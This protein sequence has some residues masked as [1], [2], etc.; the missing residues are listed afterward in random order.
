MAWD[1]MKSVEPVIN[2]GLNY[3]QVYSRQSSSSMLIP[4]FL[5]NQ[6]KFIIAVCDRA[7]KSNPLRLALE[8]KNFLLLKKVQLEKLEAHLIAKTFQPYIKAIQDYFIN[9]ALSLKI[10]NSSLSKAFLS[11]KQPWMKPTIFPYVPQPETYGYEVG[12]TLQECSLLELSEQLEHDTEKQIKLV[13]TPESSHLTPPEEVP[14]L[15]DVIRTRTLNRL[16]QTRI[17]TILSLI[18]CS[19]PVLSFLIDRNSEETNTQMLGLF[20]VIF[21]FIPLTK[22]A[23]DY[24]RYKTFTPAKMARQIREVRYCEWIYRAKAPWT[25]TLV[26]CIALVYAVQIIVGIAFLYNNRHYSVIEAAGIL[27]QAIWQ[28]EVYSTIEAAGIVKQAVWQGEVWRLVTGTLLHGNLIHFLFNAIALLGLGK[29]VE[30]IAHRVYLPI[31]FLT[32][33]LSGSL[34]SLIFLPDATSVGAS[35]GILGLLGFLVVLVWKQK[36]YLPVAFGRMLLV[37]VIYLIAIGFLARE[38]IDNAAH[39]GGFLAGFL[40][41]I[42]LIPTS[43]SSISPRVSFLL[44]K[45]SLLAGILILGFTMVSALKMLNV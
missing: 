23:W 33:A 42:I 5:K 34:F 10:S 6:E 9:F 16:R 15:F 36:R 3:L 19:F 7:P 1:D 38:V 22:Y 31:I 40:L 39:L 30:A 13:W 28:G 20:L 29:L 18:S 2:G 4:L 21:G 45:S 27:R 24:Y 35:G 8:S 44:V 37:N 11:R 25:R 41:G 43:Q 17:Y 14:F 12:E 32:S 26:C